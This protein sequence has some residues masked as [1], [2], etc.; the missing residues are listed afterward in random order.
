MTMRVTT[1]SVLKSYRSSLSSSFSKLTKARDTVLT[2]RN[3][4]SYAEDPAS[5]TQA[6]KLRRSFIRTNDQ[7]NNTE[8]VLNKFGTAYQVLDNISDLANEANDAV[9]RA[10]NDPTGSG[11]NALGQTLLVTADSMLQL[12]NS[13]YGDSFVFAGND[14]LNVPFSWQQEYKKNGD[15]YVDKY[16]EPLVHTMTN[17]VTDAYLAD[18]QTR[19]PN[20]YQSAMASVQAYAQTDANGDYVVDGDGNYLDAEGKILSFTEENKI[21]DDYIAGLNDTEKANVDAIIKRDA[22]VIKTVLY[23]GQD[24][25]NGD[26][27]LINHF[28][29]ESAFMDIGM[30]L[31]D[32]ELGELNELS[33][34]NSALCGLNFVGH[35]TDADGD[36]QNLISIV[37]E[38][39]DI[40]SR[41]DIDSGEFAH[42]EDAA[43][44]TELQLKLYDAM[45]ELTSAT[46]DLSTRASF[47]NTNAEQLTDASVLLNEQIVNIEDCDLADAITT[48]SWAQYCYNAALKVGNS[49]LS[50]SLMDYMK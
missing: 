13:K 34:F 31:K 8:S 45:G 17:N 11:R 33:A 42:D 2:Q 37:Q 4:N 35:S 1:N 20:A 43:R 40:F 28:T 44:A 18:L 41:C 38:L 21:T 19:N 23:R 16:G 46:T 14:G 27:N 5:A 47:L 50:E 22:A 39:G 29:N 36:A 6:F 3:F 7:L 15:V 24:I 48:F 9:L 49:V 25:T 30:G 32:N 10:I 12:M 26:A